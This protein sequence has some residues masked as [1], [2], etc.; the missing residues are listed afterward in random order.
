MLSEE[1][2]YFERKTARK[3]MCGKSFKQFGTKT[4]LRCLDM[5]IVLP[6]R[7]V[8]YAKSLYMVQLRII[9]GID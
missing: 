9:D 5:H 1:T 8:C 7:P 2:T 3:V 6:V 4:E